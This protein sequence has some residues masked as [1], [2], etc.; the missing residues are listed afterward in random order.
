MAALHSV[1][2]EREEHIREVVQLGCC[3]ILAPSDC[4]TND[5]ARARN[6]GRRLRLD[7]LQLRLTTV[8]SEPAL[9]HHNS[10][11]A[12][13]P[14]AAGGIAAGGIVAS[15]AFE[16][17][18]SSSSL[19]NGSLRKASQVQI[20]YP[21]LYPVLRAAEPVLRPPMMSTLRPRKTSPRKDKDASKLLV[22]YGR[23]AGT[24]QAFS[25]KRSQ[26]LMGSLWAMRRA[27][28]TAAAAAAA[29]AAGDTTA[30]PKAA[31]HGA[32]SGLGAVPESA[33]GEGLET[34]ASPVGDSGQENVG[35][36]S[37][38]LDTTAHASPVEVREDAPLM[39][40]TLGDLNDHAAQLR[41]TL[42]IL[43]EVMDPV[44]DLGGTRHATAVLAA[45]TVA[46]VKRKLELLVSMEERIKLIED[47]WARRD[48][49]FQAVLS[50]S[51]TVPPSMMSVQKFVAEHVHPRDGNP[52][53]ADRSHFQTF[54]TTFG[55]HTKHSYAERLRAIGKE[56]TEWWAHGTLREAQNGV[57]SE[58]ILRL[59]AVVTG[60]NGDSKHASLSQANAI[61][62]DR[63]AEKALRV[64]E[65]LQEKD[66][67]RVQ[68][69][70]A[71]QPQSARDAADAV[72]KEIKEAVAFGA[73]TKHPALEKAKSIADAML[74]EEKARWA[75]K[76]LRAAEKE[77][78]RD[79][80]MAE[81]ASPGVPP[82]G[83]ASEAAD[84]IEL[85]MKQMISRGA[86]ES[87]E[88]MQQAKLI[89]KSLRDE[90]GVRKRMAA[91]QKRL[92]KEAADKAAKEATT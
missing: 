39:I 50:D 27:G 64:A 30:S 11:G 48:E 20:S 49:L 17:T 62:G 74:R 88:Y 10:A 2:L 82:V 54:A 79:K 24:T 60:I 28:S 37:P 15:R 63:L 89:S 92:E 5:A 56:M 21:E 84:R 71:P 58:P 78:A 31:C 53:N 22:A 7:P 4:L 47:C 44:G 76:A 14:T 6:A 33:E 19:P 26:K 77:Q 51:G 85:E 3:E 52:L 8:S 61:L 66:T 81:K 1:R 43:E 69:S 36:D 75:L 23:D 29:S 65:T 12:V 41:T 35:E 9:L 70:S 38:P 40:S 16:Q 46:V 32:G 59:M 86:V 73:P 18:P 72:S 91:R 55:V 57:E 45:R 87:H 83:P 13:S 68:A 67:L 90:D 25:L 80:A 34:D 42:E